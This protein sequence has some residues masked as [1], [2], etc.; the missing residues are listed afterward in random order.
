MV[1]TTM[2]NEKSLI[3]LYNRPKTTCYFTDSK[4]IALYVHKLIK[5]ICL[6][7]QNN[8]QCNKINHNIID[9]KK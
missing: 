8:K 4:H 1:Y 2:V 3:N 9:K 6:L 5:N 7:S